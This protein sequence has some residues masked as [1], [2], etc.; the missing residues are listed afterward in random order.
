M[1]KHTSQR[2]AG[3][4]ARVLF[5]ASVALGAASCGDAEDLGDQG[6]DQTEQAISTQSC[7]ITY[8]QTAAKT[9][10]VGRCFR[11]CVGNMSCTGR[12]TGYSTTTCSRCW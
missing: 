8:Y 2:F 7:V 3:L 12:R 1:S 5:C 6:A 4:A 10:V 11:P 9:Q